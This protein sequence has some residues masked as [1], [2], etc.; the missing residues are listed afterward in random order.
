MTRYVLDASAVL[1][2]LNQEPG[3]DLVESRLAQSV[4]SVVN[5]VEVGTKLVDR[6]MSA[7]AAREAL[8]LLELDV[9]DFDRFMADAAVELRAE[10]KR[11]G[12][13]LADRAC[14]ALA[15]HQDAIALTSDRI[16]SQ[17]DVNCKIEVIR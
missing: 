3:A 10:T 5:A 4:M 1:A 13:S 2:V 9:I 8:G 6:G 14:L 7:D 17:L 16:W 11:A 12:L 15:I